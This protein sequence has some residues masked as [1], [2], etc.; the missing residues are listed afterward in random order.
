MQC[1]AM[2]C[3]C[4]AIVI[5]ELRDAADIMSCLADCVYYT[6]AGCM[7]AQVLQP[8]LTQK[9]PCRP[10]ALTRGPPTSIQS[11]AC[12]GNQERLDRPRPANLNSQG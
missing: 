4:A 2:V 5:N 8:R 11:K 10:L 9:L 7:L 6:T 12:V 3:R 1:A